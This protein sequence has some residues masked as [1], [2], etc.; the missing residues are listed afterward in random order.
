[1]TA[2]APIAMAPQKVTL[3]IGL[4][5]PAPPVCAPA[6]PRSASAASEPPDTAQAIVAGGETIA[7]SSGNAAPTE[8]V[9]ADVK[10]A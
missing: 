4:T 1:M 2:V 8:K 7:I 10:A 9:A 5:M 6:A 3:I